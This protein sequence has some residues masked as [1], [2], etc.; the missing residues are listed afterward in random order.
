MPSRRKNSIISA[1]YSEPPP[2]SQS[3][4]MNRPPGRST[5]STSAKIAGLS[6]ICTSESLEKTTSNCAFRKRQRTAVDQQS[7]NAVGQSARVS[8]RACIRRQQRGIDVDADHRGRVVVPAPAVSSMAP[9]PQPTSSTCAAADVA[10]LE[11]ARDLRGS[12]RRQKSVAPDDLQQRLHAVVVFARVRWAG[13][14]SRSRD[15]FW[16]LAP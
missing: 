14:F 4:A 15:S 2:R 7:S 8:M 10:S 3:L 5:R 13:R 1:E 12:A 6:G 16:R 9:R 11:Q